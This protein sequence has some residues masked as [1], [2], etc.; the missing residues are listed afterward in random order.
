MVEYDRVPNIIDEP[1]D[2]DNINQREVL[3]VEAVKNIKFPCNKILLDRYINK[4]SYDE[5]AVKYNYSNYNSAKKKKGECVKKAR[6]MISES[7]AI[8]NQLVGHA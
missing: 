4:L 6:K 3:I 7:P 5:I 8:F 1:G 2:H